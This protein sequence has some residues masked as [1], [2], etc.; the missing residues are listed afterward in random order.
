MQN[1]NLRSTVLLPLK[2]VWNDAALDSSLSESYVKILRHHILTRTVVTAAV[3]AKYPEWQSETSMYN[4][5]PVYMRKKADGT[6][7]FMSNSGW[8]ADV[9]YKDVSP[10]Q[11]I[12]PSLIII[13][14]H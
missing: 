1:P 8:V 7:Q 14:A 12:I 9:I 11:L 13:H 4:N 3:K 2:D 6:V 5:E 10:I